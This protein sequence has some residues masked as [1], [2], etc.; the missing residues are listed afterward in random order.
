MDDLRTIHEMFVVERVYAASPEQVFTWFSETE[1]KRKWFVDD[2]REDILSYQLDF[3]VGGIEQTRWKWAGGDPIPAGTV[4]GNDTVYLDIVP[5][6][7]IVLAYSM[8]MGERRFSSSLLTFE[9][10]GDGSQT[11]LKATEQGAYFE[12]GDNAEM[13][14][15]GWGSLLDTLADLI[16]A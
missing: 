4:M 3:R 2:P 15:N 9:F 11:R 10:I 5:D 16:G 1:R 7:R 14:K 8:L 13:R 6:N 12:G